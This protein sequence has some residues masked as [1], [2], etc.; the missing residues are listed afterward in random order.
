MNTPQAMHP[1]LYR[2]YQFCS[3]VKAGLPAWAGGI[4]TELTAGDALLVQTI[5][6]DAP[7][8]HL[9]NRMPPNDQRHAIA[10]ARLLQQAGYTHSALMQAALLHDVGKSIGQP[11]PHRVAIVLLEA[12]WPAAL[13]KLSAWRV[14]RGELQIANC[15]GLDRGDVSPFAD[16]QIR[17]IPL[18]RRPFVVH[19]HHPQIGAAW[20]TQVNCDPLAANLILRHQDTL[21]VITT[22]E[23]QLLA[24]LQWA[25][26]L[27]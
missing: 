13:R 11:I 3:A 27:N 24:A 10:V 17:T 21:R 2:S 25:D 22:E 19:A 6:P 7:R 16:S 26:N 12:F 8:Q 14:A 15:E 20:V 9:F 23:D 18:W 5:L 1:T 4:T